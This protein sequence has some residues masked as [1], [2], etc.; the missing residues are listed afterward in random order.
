MKLAIGLM[1]CGREDYTEASLTSFWATQG[2]SQT[3]RQAVLLHADDGS[4][5]PRNLELGRAAGFRAI[6][7]E[8]SP[9]RGQIAML[10]E[11][12]AAAVIEG[13]THFLLME[14]DWSWARS[15]DELPPI[16]DDVHAVRLYGAWKDREHI[17]AAGAHLIGTMSPIIWSELMDGWEIAAGA[18]WGGPPSITR[19]EALQ[20]VAQWAVSYKG[21]GLATAHFRT[22]RPLENFVFHIGDHTTRGFRL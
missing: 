18:H 1:T 10:R 19:L 7:P 8:N 3:V 6:T 5:S 14:N 20:R 17:R 4:P 15:L 21:I 13:A 12:I 9:R 11:L 22:M 2:G 16:P